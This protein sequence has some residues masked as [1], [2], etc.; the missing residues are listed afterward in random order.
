MRKSITS[1]LVPLILF[2]GLTV[3][4]SAE[5]PPD[6]VDAEIANAPVDPTLA[7]MNRVPLKIG[8]SEARVT[9]VALM[10]KTD[11]PSGQPTLYVADRT[12]RLPTQFVSSDPRRGPYV[13][14]EWTFDT[15]R[16][17]A[18]S[19]VNGIPQIFYLGPV[20]TVSG[21]PTGTFCGLY[22]NWH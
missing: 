20:R 4:V 1:L 9:Q 13:G 11:Y 22:G 18:L 16:A 17:Q 12:L 21:I 2:A 15:R 3:K 19:L 6:S 7:A 10:V 5:Q 14:L 8:A